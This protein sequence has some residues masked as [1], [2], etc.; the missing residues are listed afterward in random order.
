MHAIDYAVIACYLLIVVGIGAWFSRGERDTESYLL[1]GRS[2]PWPIIAISY[3]VSLLSTISIVAIPGEAYN[4]GLTQM[5]P[6]LM[7]PFLTV[8]AFHLFVRFYF[9]SRAFTPFQYLELRFNAGIRALSAV[10][11]LFLRTVYLGMALYATARVFEGASDWPK[12]H[13]ILLIGVIG[14]AYTVMGGLRAVVWTDFIQFIV[15]AGG[16]LLILIKIMSVVPGGAAGIVTFALEHNRGMPELTDPSFY[17]MSPYARLTLWGMLFIVLNDT[18]FGNCADQIALQRLLS[19]SSYQKAR[20]SVYLYL[21]IILPV[22]GTLWFLGLAIFSFYH[23]QPAERRPV[24][25]DLALF[26]FIATELPTP[27]PGLILASMLAAVM[28]TLDS[29]INSLATV[30]TKDLYQRFIRPDASEAGQVAV[31][32]SLTLATGV[33]AI[34]SGLALSR[35]TDETGESVLET[36]LMWLSMSVALPPVYLLGIFS[37]RATAGHALVT[38]L[39]GCLVTGAMICWYLWSQNTERPLSHLFVVVPGLI[40]SPVVGYLVSR[41]S[42]RRPD[43]EL[44][45]LTLW[46]LT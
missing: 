25:G 28:S 38:L 8:G 24:Q 10:F 31:S 35:L 16:I 39:V 9:K 11:Y 43:S 3:L 1:G 7:L 27:L 34:L 42:P 22:L 29:G 19:T 40:I 33:I 37:R 15:L 14:I 4:H 12:H 36:S 23:H 32:R 44:K 46:T 41:R 18:L 6:A 5:L 30:G 21:A 2:M 20:R 26:R 45:D 17:S 13:T